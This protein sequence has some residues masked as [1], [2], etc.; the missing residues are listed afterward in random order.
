[1]DECTKQ[2]RSPPVYSLTWLL[3]LFTRH[4]IA[5]PSAQSVSGLVRRVMNGERVNDNP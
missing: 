3:S 5:M 1:M 2:R 4:L